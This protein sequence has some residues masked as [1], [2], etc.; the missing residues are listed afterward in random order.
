MSETN[1]FN[2]NY[3]TLYLNY[4]SRWMKAASNRS[5][6]SYEGRP[7]SNSGRPTPVRMYDMNALYSMRDAT[8]ESMLKYIIMTWLIHEYFLENKWESFPLIQGAMAFLF[9]NKMATKTQNAIEFQNI[10]WFLLV[11]HFTFSSEFE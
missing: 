11:F 2:F 1:V 7:V 3:N 4:D 6:W 10:S 8:I 5:S 9:K